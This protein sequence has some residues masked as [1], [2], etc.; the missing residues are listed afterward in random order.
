MPPTVRQRYDHAGLS[1]DEHERDS[2]ARLKDAGEFFFAAGELFFA[3]VLTAYGV[4]GYYLLQKQLRVMQQQTKLMQDQVADARRSAADADKLTERQFKIAESQAESLKTLAATNKAMVTANE[5]QVVVAESQATSLGRQADALHSQL[6]PMSLEIE[7]L[8]SQA[9]S[10]RTLADANKAIAQAASI[11]ADA[12]KRAADTSAQQLE[13]TDRPWVR[14][15]A[16]SPARFDFASPSFDGPQFT[17]HDM[18]NVEAGDLSHIAVI[19]LVDVALTNTG[20]SV[21][22]DIRV[23]VRGVFPEPK[24]LLAPMDASVFIFARRTLP[25]QPFPKGSAPVVSLSGCSWL[26]VSHTRSATLPP[27]TEHG[28]HTDSATVAPNNSRGRTP[29]VGFRDRQRSS[30]AGRFSSTVGLGRKW[31]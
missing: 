2:F 23:L 22:N 15:A 14:V 27:S 24:E 1:K 4:F 9:A 8:N 5:R 29:T 10:M 6:E 28:S 19:F 26:V 16:V 21:A 30:S 11:S 25:R 18:A 31:S 12:A 17:P 3:A 20:R 7:A 13:I